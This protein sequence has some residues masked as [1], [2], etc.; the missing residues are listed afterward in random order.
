MAVFC[1]R[2]DDECNSTSETSANF[3]STTPRNNTKTPIF[4]LA[5]LRT[6]NLTG[7]RKRKYSFVLMSS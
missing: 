3:Y 1:D 2:P 5:V 7:N 4:I 6:S